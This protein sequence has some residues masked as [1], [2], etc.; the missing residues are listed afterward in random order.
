MEKKQFRLGG[1]RGDNPR[2]R[3]KNAGFIALL[4]LF[5]LVIWAAFNQPS[6]L[7]EVPFSQVISQANEGKLERIT[8][9]GNNLEITPKGQTKATERST[10]EEGSSIY[11]QG[12][13]QD[14]VTVAV[15]PQS[16]SNVWV[17]IIA[18]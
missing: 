1:G 8:I 6:K 2:S 3:M 11:E 5:G 13:K 10:K 4:V 16:S 9:K 12:L 17:T 18:N 14:K 15:E 7:K